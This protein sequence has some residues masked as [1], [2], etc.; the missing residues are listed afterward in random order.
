MASTHLEVERKYDAGPDAQ[1]PDLS[2]LHGVASVSEP[3]RHE[4]EAVYFDTADLALARARITLRRRTGGDDAGWHLKL[5]VGSGGREEVRLPLGQAT[6]TPPREL[7]TAVMAYTRGRQLRPVATLRTSRTVQRLLSGDGGCLAEVCQ[8]A[9]RAFDGRSSHTLLAWHEWEVELVE[10]GEDLLDRVDALMDSAG[11][12][13][14]DA[15][16]KL[17]RVLGDRVPAPPEPVRP[18]RKGPVGALL[19]AR[20]VEQV[21]VLKQRDVDVRRDTQEGVHQ[22]RVAMRRLRSALA[23]FRPLVNREVTDPLREEL[24]WIAGLLG[25]ARDAEV[26]ARRLEQVVAEQPAELVLGAVTARIQHTLGNRYR[27]G[28][29]AALRAMESPRYFE[30]LVALDELAANPPWTPLAQERVAA[31]LPR[32]LRRD[33]RRLQDQVAKIGAATDQR[34]RD[35]ALH[36]SRK[37]AKRLR[38]AAEAARPVLGKKAD[39]VVADGKAAQNLLGDHQDS[40]V[41]QNALRDMGV[42]AHLDGDNAFTFGLLHGL[43][44]Q[45]AATLVDQFDRAWTKSYEPELRRILG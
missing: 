29:A 7:R 5:P 9:V 43:E 18:R 8:D 16:S 28:L 44:Q 45:R 10:G 35:V 30:L 33:W 42:Q 27:D 23:T 2:G 12:A 37:A 3:E 17:A 1:L 14:A 34:E 25:Q 21:E 38:Y 13:P 40:V 4:L 32:L 24:Q 19:Q 15:P 11:V 6:R 39:R 31:V 36:E 22:L 20:L 26:M 41:T